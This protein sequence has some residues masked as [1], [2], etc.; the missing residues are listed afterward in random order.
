MTFRQCSESLF[1][2][3]HN[4]SGN[5][6]SALIP[7]LYFTWQLMLGLLS[8]GE[9]KSLQTQLSQVFM[10]L[11]GVSCTFDMWTSVIYHLYHPMGHH[12][13]EKLLAI[14]MSG[15]CAVILSDFIVIAFHLFS[16]WS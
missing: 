16:E 7:A 6:F 1:G 12:V 9:H 3:L 13:C 15:I 2:Y 4:E 11:T 10:F 5:V 14:D 8:Q